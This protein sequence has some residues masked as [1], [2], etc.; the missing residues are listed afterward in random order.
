[1]TCAKRTDAISEGASY[2]ITRLLSLRAPFLA[3]K[4]AATLPSCKVCHKLTTQS[5]RRKCLIAYDQ[6]SI[7]VMFIQILLDE[8]NNNS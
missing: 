3:R 2:K 7:L 5:L 1:M 6:I 4:S 8:V